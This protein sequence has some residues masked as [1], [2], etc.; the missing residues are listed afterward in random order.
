MNTSYYSNFI[1][2][3]LSNI[4]VFFIKR[5]FYKPFFK[6]FFFNFVVTLDPSTVLRFRFNGE[7]NKTV[8]VAEN[9]R[10]D[11]LCQADGRPTPQMSLVSIKDNNHMLSSTSPGDI[12]VTESTEE[13][14]YTMNQVQCEHAGDY[15]CEVNNGIGHDSHTVKLLVFCK[16][17]FLLSFF[18]FL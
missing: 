1:I 18:L 2:V 14:S 3:F 8:I 4:S 9:S 13:L 10:V 12:Q 17:V 5:G 15:R 11:L 6:S 16:S 7:D